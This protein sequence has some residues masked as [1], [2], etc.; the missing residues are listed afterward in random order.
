[1]WSLLGPS[2]LATAS[3]PPCVRPAPRPAAASPVGNVTLDASAS[4]ARGDTLVESLSVA[5]TS[6]PPPPPPGGNKPPA[7]KREFPPR[8]PPPLP[9]GRPTRGVAPAPAFSP[10]APRGLAL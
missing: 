8:G 2:T 10:H 4:V 5:P 1:M 3:T 6:P 7:Q 9:C